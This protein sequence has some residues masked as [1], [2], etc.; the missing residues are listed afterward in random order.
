MMNIFDK[1]TEEDPTNWFGNV[2][3]GQLL[4]STRA[5]SASPLNTRLCR[6]IL[7]RLLYLVAVQADPNPATKLTHS[8]ATDLF[9]ATTKLFQ[10]RDILL[11]RTMHLLLKEL[12][13]MTD[14]A[15]IIV[16]SLT[17][18]LTCNVETYRSN[19][20]RLLSRIADAQLL[21]QIDRFMRSA[22][23]DKDPAVS[24]AALVSGLHLMRKCPE[25]VRR[26]GSEVQDM[27]QSRQQMVQYHSLGL[28]HA[29]R[30]GDARDRLAVSKLITSSAA[31]GVKSPLASVALVRFARQVLFDDPNYERNKAVLM[32]I[33]T[34]LRN[35]N[36]MV[37]LEAARALCELPGIPAKSLAS[38]VSELQL[39]LNSSKITLRFAAVRTLNTLANS[40]PNAVSVANFDLEN[41]VNDSNRSV[42]TLAIA[43][44]L[45][46]GTE[47]NVDRLITLISGFVG[48][49]PD[50][51]K[52]QLI[53]ALRILSLKYESK[54]KAIISLFSSMLREEGNFDFK[55]AIVRGMVA[56]ALKMPEHKDSALLHMCEFIEDCE[57][58]LLATEILNFIAAEG[59]AMPSASRLVRYVYNRTA[60][61]NATV[62]AT[63]VT[64]LAK[65][66]LQVP[67]LR[68]Q[69]ITLLERCCFDGEDEVRDRAVFYLTALRKAV[70]KEDDTFTEESLSAIVN[71][72]F[73]LPLDSFI[74]SLE[75]YLSNE[76]AWEHPFDLEALTAALPGGAAPA[77]AA[78]TAASSSEAMGIS[79]IIT[80]SPF[81]ET[82]TP[83]AAPAATAA[84]SAAAGGKS[85]ASESPASVVPA[86]SLAYAQG[87]A[88]KLGEK[89]WRCSADHPIT[90][91]ETEYVVSYRKFVF[92]QHA[93]FEFTITNTIKE[94][95]LENVTVSLKPVNTTFTVEETT[96][97][98]VCAYDEPA[99][100]YAIVKLP[101]KTS[102]A[103]ENVSSLLSKFSCILQFTAKDVDPATN[104]PAEDDEGMDDEYPLDDAEL[105][106]GDYIQA[107]AVPSFNDKWEA[108]GE[109][110]QCVKMYNLSTMKSIQAAVDE[111]VSFFGM[112]TLEGSDVVPAPGKKH[113]LYMSGTFASGETIV[114][115]AR[116]RTDPASTNGYGVLIELAVRSP[117]ANLSQ[118]IASAV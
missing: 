42:A 44:L 89:L 6:Q 63:A 81:E 7:S 94:Q 91:L 28:A 62:R 76:S 93:A 10:S 36:D 27:M 87:L 35:P 116:M 49:V 99:H 103:G 12:V 106:I 79:S 104:A 109:D 14:S 100:A 71:P 96:P 11:R 26:W 97:A 82:I 108:L 92:E 113:I 58:P 50:D 30:R 18:D 3:K 114:V 118:L 52:V 57:Y 69:I 5:F 21:A 8:E 24:S 38:A 17:K 85:A 33:E 1:K 105:V 40:Q 2:D 9:F 110:G 32:F 68:P 80:S 59:P 111:L 47:A 13:P 43:C 66:G 56:I 101:V 39:F 83:T 84:T 70:S 77:P 22:L 90:E 60:L 75:G 67:S 61:E 37:V 29:I 78:G 51:F 72:S 98:A 117:N 54:A 73:V 102:E 45:K 64:A 65:F 4:I 115:R 46:T 41:L 48:D 74:G 112:T 25:A 107:R 16:S 86:A 23:V 15:I 31:N 20:I 53:S 34:S 88:D 95:Q 19:A 55:A